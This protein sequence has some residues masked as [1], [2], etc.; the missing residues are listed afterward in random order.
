MIAIYIVGPSVKTSR[1]VVF[2]DST[3]SVVEKMAVM[4]R[5]AP[6]IEE[7]MGLKDVLVLS[8][9]SSFEPLVCK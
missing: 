2:V 5:T 3:N 7:N 8:Y 1:N 9:H 4:T 6:E